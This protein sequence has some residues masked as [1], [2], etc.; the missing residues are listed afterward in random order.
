MIQ[1]FRLPVLLSVLQ[2][3][4]STLPYNNSPQYAAVQ[5][6]RVYLLLLSLSHSLFFSVSQLCNIYPASKLQQ[7]LDPSHLED[8]F[9]FAVCDRGCICGVWLST[10]INKLS[11]QH[12]RTILVYRFV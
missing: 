1:Q 11:E 10:T 12:L 4:C 7:V 3:Q 2:S 8:V 6:Q 5:C 9:N